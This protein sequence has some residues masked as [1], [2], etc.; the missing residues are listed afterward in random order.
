MET[1]KEILNGWYIPAAIAVI[2]AIWFGITYYRTNKTV[3]KIR[4]EYREKVEKC[5]AKLQQIADYYNQS[6]VA[7]LFGNPPR[8][9]NAHSGN[10]LPRMNSCEL[11]FRRIIPSSGFFK[12]GLILEFE[13]ADVP[14]DDPDK[15]PRAWFRPKNNAE[16]NDAVVKEISHDN[17]AIESKTLGRIDIFNNKKN[18]RVGMPI[19]LYQR[20]KKTPVGY[21]VW[22]T[23]FIEL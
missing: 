16:I 23:P 13:G 12:K 10:A 20:V 3:N 19:T 5:N 7:L 18:V 11:R 22:Y 17:I 8:F 14:D 1:L 9:I 15:P 4:R 21:S 2:C 6:K